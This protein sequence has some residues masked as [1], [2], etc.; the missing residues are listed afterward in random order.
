VL[1][2]NQDHLDNLGEEAHILNLLSLL[3][4][5]IDFE[6]RAVLRLRLSLLLVG[7]HRLHSSE[8]GLK[9]ALDQEGREKLFKL[10]AI[11]RTL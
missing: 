5:S 9:E 6:P 11:V 4:L 10:S 7:C 3:E 1:K 2:N 8:E